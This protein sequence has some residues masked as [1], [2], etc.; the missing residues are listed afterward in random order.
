MQTG[1]NPLR[2]YIHTCIHKIVSSPGKNLCPRVYWLQAEFKKKKKVLNYCRLVSEQIKKQ[3]LLSV[4]TYLWV[5]IIQNRFQLFQFFFW[6]FAKNFILIKI[7]VLVQV[8]S[9]WECH[10]LGSSKF[11]KHFRIWVLF[12]TRSIKRNKKWKKATVQVNVPI[13][14]HLQL[15]NVFLKGK[16]FIQYS[17][18]SV[19]L[20]QIQNDW[21]PC[22]LTDQ[23]PILPCP[24][25]SITRIIIIKKL[26]RYLKIYGVIS[27]EQGRLWDGD[28]MPVIPG[29][30]KPIL[31]L[32][33]LQILSQKNS[34]DALYLLLLLLFK[35]SKESFTIKRLFGYYWLISLPIINRGSKGCL[36]ITSLQLK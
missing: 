24:F 25:P 35:A 2:C 28:E 10:D 27:T 33:F 34:Q 4:I 31:M 5:K 9:K 22:F 8:L 14:K 21:K 30:Y 6:K 19:V 1:N 29:N 12:S 7:F 16:F 17:C 26:H 23:N 20:W 13:K 36:F 18:Q 3:Q 11:L 32:L 15:L